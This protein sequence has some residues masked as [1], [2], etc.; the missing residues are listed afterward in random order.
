MPANKI[1]LT[2]QYI[3]GKESP[4]LPIR[5][6]PNEQLVESIIQSYIYDAKII[7]LKNYSALSSNK[8]GTYV[9]KTIY[10]TIECLCGYRALIIT[11]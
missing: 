7:H 11:R 3:I 9:R 10:A 6:V 2:E 5:K 1:L 8:F 4:L